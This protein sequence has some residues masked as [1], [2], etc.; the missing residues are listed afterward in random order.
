MNSIAELL[1]HYVEQNPPACGDAQVVVVSS[2]FISAEIR[3]P[4]RVH[5][6]SL[7]SCPTFYDP[8]DCSSP[9]SSAH[10]ILPARILE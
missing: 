5:G 9:V 8:M 7:Q 6:K 3:I 1:K 10:G 4:W 2:K